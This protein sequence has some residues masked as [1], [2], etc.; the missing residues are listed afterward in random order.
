MFGQFQI[1]TDKSDHNYTNEKS[2]QMTKVTPNDKS[3][4]LDVKNGHQITKV[5]LEYRSMLMSFVNNV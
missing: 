4:S 2:P 1:P 5:M 3:D